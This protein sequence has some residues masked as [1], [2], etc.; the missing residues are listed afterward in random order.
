MSSSTKHQQMQTTTISFRSLQHMTVT[1][2]N[3]KE[4]A[5]FCGGS[6]ATPP[7]QHHDAGQRV[8]TTNDMFIGEGWVITRD[9]Y[10]PAFVFYNKAV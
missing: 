4:A 7:W 6:V 2:D 8:R 1:N 3:L 5:E 9:E 10:N